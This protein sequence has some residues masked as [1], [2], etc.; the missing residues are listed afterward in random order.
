MFIAV[1]FHPFSMSGMLYQMLLISFDLSFSLAFYS[2]P[3]QSG[4]ADQKFRKKLMLIGA[5]IFPF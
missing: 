2:I 3:D 4:L 1:Y 5:N